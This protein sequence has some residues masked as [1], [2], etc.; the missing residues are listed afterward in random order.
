MG[1]AGI[2]IQVLTVKVEYSTAG[3]LPMHKLMTT[4]MATAVG[5]RQC[6]ER[7]DG[8]EAVGCFLQR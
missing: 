8:A 4:A 2:H 3:M 1:F 7:L 6:R 5:S